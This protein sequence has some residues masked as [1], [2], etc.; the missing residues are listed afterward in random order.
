[1]FDASAE[2]D[3]QT[4]MIATRLQHISSFPWKYIFWLVRLGQRDP[5]SFLAGVGHG[6]MYGT[7]SSLFARRLHE[8]K[9]SE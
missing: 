6:S 1:M 8:I 7:S 5:C 4:E 2:K 9:L 3:R